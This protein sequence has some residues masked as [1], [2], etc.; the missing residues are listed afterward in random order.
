[1]GH[2]L[3]TVLALVPAGHGDARAPA[4]RS[5]TGC[6][7]PTWPRPCRPWPGRASSSRRPGRRGGYRLARPATEITLLDVVLAVDGDEPAFRCTRDPPAGAGAR[8]RPA[9]TRRACSI[10]AAMW[11]AEEAWRAELA[12]TTVADLLIALATTVSTR[13]RRQGGAAWM[14]EVLRM[15]I[16]S[17]GRPGVLG[18]RV[19]PLLVAAGHEVTGSP[20]IA[21]EGGGAH[22]R[23]APT[24]V[25]VDLF[26]PAAVA[27]AV[28]GHDVVCNL[29]THIPPLADGVTPGAWAEN[30]RIRTE[31]SRNLVDAALAAGAAASS[32]SR[33]PSSTRTAATGGSTRTAPLADGPFAASVRAAEAQRRPLHGR[34]RHRCRAALRACSTAPAPRTPRT[35]CG[36]PARAW[37]PSSAGR[38]ATSR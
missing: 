18:R 28:A 7:P 23:S 16:S 10:A 22:A 38:S 37:R 19:V 25:A 9:S 11:R 20:A 1:M 4:W 17:R 29:A 36:W 8:Y 32:R 6:R 35:S 14:Q 21:R 33:S 5:S 30:D 24:P 27:A 3:R 12:A 13:G 31:A 2:P 26:D 34:R 15:K